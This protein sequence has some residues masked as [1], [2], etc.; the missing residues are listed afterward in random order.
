[1]TTTA[2]PP[3]QSSVDE[4]DP[5]SVRMSIGEH[6]DELRH[7]LIR[8]LVGFAVA[9]LVCIGFGNRVTTFFCKPLIHVL[10]EK[11]LNTQLY[12]TEISDGFMVPLRIGIICGVVVASPWMA[13]Q[14]WKFVAA[15]LY[16]RERKYV[17]KYLPL[18]IALLLSGML[19]VYYLV[20]PM[21]IWFFV[22]VGNAI[23]LPNVGSPQT[24]IVPPGGI[25]MAPMLN[26]DPANP[27]PGS[28]WFNRIDGRLKFYL[29]KDDLRVIPFGPSNLLAPQFSLPEY[30][31]LVTTSLLTFG[32]GF[33]MPLVVLALV[34]IGILEIDTVKKSRRYVYFLMS[35]VA[36]AMTPG[37]VVTAMLALMVPLILLFEF[38]IWLAGRNP[39]KTTED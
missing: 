13:Y 16:P 32:L 23:P 31:S 14:I 26:G 11:N 22:S 37:D 20:L 24:V 2:P 15:G 4:Y 19:F 27:A 33:Q 8:A 18:S 28:F 1:M 12:Y 29:N 35:I 10:Q 25:P 36:A 7:R 5:D 17:T 3:P 6:L 9:V 34:R 39:P 38:G 21:T 30:I